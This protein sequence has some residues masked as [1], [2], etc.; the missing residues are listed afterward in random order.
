LLTVAK[1]VFVICNSS[2]GGAS[3]GCPT[4]EER[5]QAALQKN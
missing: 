2:S 3:P 4:M 5:L 1:V